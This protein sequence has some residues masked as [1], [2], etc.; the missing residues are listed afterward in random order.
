M[1]PNISGWQK[2]R[3]VITFFSLATKFHIVLKEN[4]AYMYLCFLQ[5]RCGRSVWISNPTYLPRRIHGRW[6]LLI[7]GTPQQI[8]VNHTGKFEDEKKDSNL[9]SYSTLQGQALFNKSF[10]IDDQKKAT[11]LADGGHKIPPKSVNPSNRRKFTRGEG[12][13]EG[14]NRAN[15]INIFRPHQVFKLV[16][17]PP[18]AETS[19][20]R[21]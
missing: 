14:L 16:P 4:W 1:Y 6:C 18:S 15:K 19:N 7:R 8:H 13:F 11:R 9:C 20:I 2:N 5:V 12:G 21:K 17:A 10:I 3:K